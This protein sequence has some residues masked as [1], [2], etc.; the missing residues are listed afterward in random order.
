MKKLLLQLIPCFF[1]LFFFGCFCLNDP[2]KDVKPDLT[3]ENNQLRKIATQLGVSQ[4]RALQLN[5]QELITD[6]Q[7]KINE[8][9]EYQGG[10]LSEEEKRQIKDLLYGED[11]ILKTLEAYDFFIHK[12]NNSR[13][14][15][16]PG[17][18]SE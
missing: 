2:S 4:S 18:K 10:Y 17:D 9:D 1:S 7:I 16:L 6:I 14:I 13:I 5:M 15:F 8:T 3:W 11:G 12:I